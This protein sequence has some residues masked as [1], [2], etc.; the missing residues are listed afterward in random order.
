MHNLAVIAVIS[1]ASVSLV[2]I[3]PFVGPYMAYKA[4]TNGSDFLAF[5]WAFGSIVSFYALHL[6]L[7][8]AAYISSF[9]FPRF[10]KRIGHTD[11]HEALMKA[12]QARVTAHLQMDQ[13]LH[14]VDKIEIKNSLGGLFIRTSADGDR[15]PSDRAKA[16]IT[17]DFDAMIRAK[18][19][20]YASFVLLRKS[21][22]FAPVHLSN[23][24][25]I[26]AVARAPRSTKLTFATWNGRCARTS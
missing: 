21:I 26:E 11:E 14:R 18:Y 22:S 7:I 8:I 16:A 2:F 6:D 9:A 5:L 3:L 23:H 25:I 4:Y 24:D 13:S 20:R 17:K 12:F 1:I 19:G 15:Q 10:H